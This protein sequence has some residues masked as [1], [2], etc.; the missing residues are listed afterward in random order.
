MASPH[1]SADVP[2]ETH[3]NTSKILLLLLLVTLGLTIVACAPTL[4]TDGEPTTVTPP[5]PASG[6]AT[7]EPTFTATMTTVAEPTVAMTSSTASVSPTP[8]PTAAAP[9]ADELD[10]MGACHEIDINDLFSA[11]AKPQPVHHQGR[12]TCLSCHATLAKPALPA[13]HLGRLDA[14]CSGCHKSN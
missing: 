13:T 4:K 7:A 11:G 6:S 2:R 14:A 5:P 8:L 3:L 12:T 9:A 10:C 1:Q